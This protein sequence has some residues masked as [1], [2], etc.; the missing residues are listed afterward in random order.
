LRGLR[1][2]L[3]EIEHAL[4]QYESIQDAVTLV[5]NDALVAYIV[6]TETTVD[7][8]SIRTS[9]RQYL[10]DYMIPSVYMKLDAMPLTPNGKIDRKALPE[11]DYEQ[12]M[13]NSYVAPSSETEKQL[14]E[15]WSEILDVDKVGVQDNFFDIGGHSLMATQVISKIREVFQCEIP[16]RDIFDEPNIENL[17]KIIDEVLADGGASSVESIQRIDRS[18]ADVDDESDEEESDGEIDLDD[19]DDDELEGLADEL[20]DLDD[21][22]L[23]SLLGDLMDEDD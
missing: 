6:S 10:P 1:I 18:I 2:E 21:E 16:L 8:Q 5:Q 19:I 11:P 3:G 4:E 22:D 12:M 9:M 13:S 23:E 20:D 15:I 7:R 17:A 14:V